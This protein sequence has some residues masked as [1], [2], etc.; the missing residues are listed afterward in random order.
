MAWDLQVT[1]VIL[2]QPAKRVEKI[3]KWINNGGLAAPLWCT[4]PYLSPPPF[5]TIQILLRN[6]HMQS[7]AA[8]LP[9]AVKTSDDKYIKTIAKE[10]QCSTEKQ[11]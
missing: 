3:L 6:H 1:E 7:Q 4:N 11:R 5:S 8:Q 2:H 10:D 9:Q